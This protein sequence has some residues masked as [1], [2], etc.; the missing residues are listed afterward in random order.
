MVGGGIGA[1]TGSH[2]GKGNGRTAA[3]IGG[4][5]LGAIIGNDLGRAG[6]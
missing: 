5:I 2:I 4:T 3:I 6:H 1:F